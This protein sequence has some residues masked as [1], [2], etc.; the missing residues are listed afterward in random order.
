LLTIA[1]MDYATTT[2]NSFFIAVR[3][4]VAMKFLDFELDLR[5]KRRVR[6]V[7]LLG[8]LLKVRRLNAARWTAMQKRLVGDEAATRIQLQ[9]REALT[10]ALQNADVAGELWRDDFAVFEQIQ[11]EFRNKLKR[12][13]ISERHVEYILFYTF[14]ITLDEVMSL[15]LYAYEYKGR[16]VTLRPGATFAALPRGFD[17]PA[18]ECE[19]ERHSVQLLPRN[20]SIG[21]VIDGTCWDDLDELQ[22]PVPV[23]MGRP[24]ATEARL[25]YEPGKLPGKFFGVKAADP[26]AHFRGLRSALGA[27]RMPGQVMVL[28]E[29][30][31]PTEAIREVQADLPG[32]DIPPMVL[33][34][35][36]AHVLD[37]GGRRRNRIPVLV[38]GRIVGFHDKR[39]PDFKTPDGLLEEFDS[40][41]AVIHIWLG[42]YLSFSPLFAS[43]FADPQIREVLRLLRPDLILC[44]G[45]PLSPSEADELMQMALKYGETIGAAIFVASSAGPNEV[46]FYYELS[47]KINELRIITGWEAEAFIT[48][49]E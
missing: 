31:V 30:S 11:A 41:D 29:L 24:P 20:G 7:D 10:A 15:R 42:P 2:Q 49:L 44:P 32:C 36:S 21:V 19:E 39:H 16:K 14:F 37:E 43:D 17:Q 9:L 27:C 18:S 3:A 22:P 46:M 4:W 6:I 23:G 47:N 25:V 28:P 38:R 5:G 33:V 1:A 35:G 34:M 13:A 40:T 48:V 26:D 8:E 12:D 45:H